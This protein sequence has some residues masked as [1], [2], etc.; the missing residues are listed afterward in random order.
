VLKDLK[1]KTKMLAKILVAVAAACPLLASASSPV[2]AIPGI[3]SAEIKAYATSKDKL[4]LSE[5]LEVSRPGADRSAELKNRFQKAQRQW[6]AGNTEAARSE[7]RALTELSQKADWRDPQREVLQA[8]YLRLAQ[9]ASSG[10][11]K[12]SWLEAAVRFFADLDPNPALFPPPLIEEFRAA[13]HRLLDDAPEF[14]PWEVFPE[15]RYVLIDGR[16]IETKERKPI[17]LAPGVHRVTALSDT[18]VAI[19]EF[20]TA[21]QLRLFR[22]SPVSLVEGSCGTARLKSDLTQLRDAEIYSGASC[23]GDSAKPLELKP[24]YLASNGLPLTATQRPAQ[25]E[26]KKTWYWVLGGAIIAGA[27]YALVRE[28]NKEKGPETVHRSGF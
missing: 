25:V 7:F 3:G 5:H 13:K 8:S 9:S 19:T 28:M 1:L 27:G 23:T 15:S 12:S 2:V 10:T 4:T 20:L 18:H 21:S 14:E 22:A 6:L 16:K 17:R 26:G 24:Q 11:E